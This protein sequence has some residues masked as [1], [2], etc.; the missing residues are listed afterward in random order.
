MLNEFYSTIVAYML[1]LFTKESAFLANLSAIATILVVLFSCVIGIHKVVA[2]LIM[3]LTNRRLNEYLSQF[4]T[5]LDIRQAIAHYIPTR[6]QNI[7]P[8][9]H[10]EPQLARAIATTTL[11][12]PRFRHYLN[13]DDEL[14]YFMILADTGMGKTTFMINLF[15]SLLKP[16][17]KR[18]N[19]QLIPMGHPD[20]MDAIRMMEDKAHTI[21]LIDALDE[22]LEANHDAEVRIPEILEETARFRK[23]VIASRTQF[24]ATQS[25]V[26]D[27]T[28]VLKYGGQKGEYRFVR[29]YISPLSDKEV[30]RY[31]RKKYPIFQLP[32]RRR[33][34]RIVSDCPYLAVRPMLLNHIDA[35]LRARGSTATRAEI[36]KAMI[37]GWIE[38]ERV[39]DKAEL[40]RLSYIFANEMLRGAS[41]RGG[42]FIGAEDAVKVLKE[43]GSQLSSV[44]FRSRS[45]VNRDASGN[46][47]FAHKSILE[48]LIAEQLSEGRIK[49]E[50]RVEAG[51]L[52]QIVAFYSEI[53]IHDWVLPLFKIQYGEETNHIQELFSSTIFRLGKISLGTPSRYFIKAYIRLLKIVPPRRYIS[54]LLRVSL[55]FMKLLS[56]SPELVTSNTMG[57]IVESGKIVRFVSRGKTCEDMILSRYREAFNGSFKFSFDLESDLISV[58]EFA[59]LY[60]NRDFS[61]F[62]RSHAKRTASLERVLDCFERATKPFFA[63]YGITRKGPAMEGFPRSSFL[64]ERRFAKEKALNQ[65]RNEYRQA[66]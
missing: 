21:L 19:I 29:M 61:S 8:S 62:V 64:E 7:D 60:L 15:R 3:C 36:Y 43:S 30:L 41:Y 65:F 45:L 66:I 14:K 37:A 58:L 11:L 4:L 57:T 31:L 48:F 63:R 59:L 49:L 2:S 33:A 24:F 5:P 28:G 6:G 55:S 9:T 27:E 53:F 38:R 17:S 34:Y 42:F 13:K 47:K 1:E 20:A 52:D 35:I 22:D 56:I 10:D 32:L 46:Y 51:Y 25:D 40:L 18:E 23:V 12:L 39:R 54:R 26:P 44:D 50:C 16:L